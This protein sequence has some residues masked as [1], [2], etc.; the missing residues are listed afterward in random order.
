MIHVEQI[1]LY[2]VSHT[3]LKQIGTSLYFFLYLIERFFHPFIDITRIHTWHNKNID[4]IEPK[5]FQ[6]ILCKNK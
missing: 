1:Q 4:Q 3:F 6:L 2:R 5:C